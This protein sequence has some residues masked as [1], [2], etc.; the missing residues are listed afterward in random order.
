MNLIIILVHFHSACLSHSM[1]IF[2][3]S[4]LLD[5]NEVM[6]LHVFLYSLETQGKLK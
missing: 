4:L 2:S 3:A 5:T 1:I 6:L